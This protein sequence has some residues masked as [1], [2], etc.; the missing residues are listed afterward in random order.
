[1]CR[2]YHITTFGC[3]MNAYESELMEGMLSAR[4]WLP[5]P[6]EDQADIVIYNTC[7]VREGAEQRAMARLEQLKALKRQRPGLIVGVTGCMAQKEADGLRRSLPH[8]DLILGT[9]AIPRLNPLLDTLLATGQPQVCVDMLD[10]AYPADVT[11][12]RH[13]RLKALVTIMLGCNKN[14]SYCIVPRT[15][16]RE[17]SRPL[18][19]ILAEVRGLVEEGY[20]EITLVGQNVNSY[21]WQGVAFGRLLR[22]VDAV[23]GEAWIRY[24]TS[25]PRDCNE[26]HIAAVAEC[27]NICENFHLPAQSGSSPVL[28]NMYRGYTRERYLDLVARV[29]AA[30][31]GATLS[32]DLIVGFPGESDEE[33]RQT[34]DLVRQV[35]FDSAF[36]YMYSPRPGTPAAEQFD[37]ATALKIFQ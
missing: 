28:R 17:V 37:V 23:A 32:T 9:R 31:P 3:Q 35:R 12:R 24:I 22:E 5:A 11:P 25:H 7:V 1:M 18:D 19:T 26:A 34:L 29:R 2:T 4:G 30:V 15:R 6:A 10:D 14:C 8:L 20:R 27:A 36:M 33:Y 21:Q 16:G 13:N